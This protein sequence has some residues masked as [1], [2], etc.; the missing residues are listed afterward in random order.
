[1]IFQY[2]NQI[3]SE[4]YWKKKEEKAMKKERNPKISYIKLSNNVKPQT[5]VGK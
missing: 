3:N 5:A 4:I 2:K 1:M